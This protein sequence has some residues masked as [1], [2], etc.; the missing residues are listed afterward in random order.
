MEIVLSKTILPETLIDKV[1]SFLDPI[2]VIIKDVQIKFMFDPKEDGC[3]VKV[4]DP[5]AKTEKF[6]KIYI[7]WIKK[8]GQ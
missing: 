2:N 1:I 6:K 5:I 7:R 8:I 4:I 3:I